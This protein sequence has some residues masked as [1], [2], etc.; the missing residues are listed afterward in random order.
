[1]KREK[2]CPSVINMKTY[3]LVIQF[4][5]IAVAYLLACPVS[6]SGAGAGHG[7]SATIQ[8]PLPETSYVAMEAQHAENSEGE[9]GLIE[10]LK[11]R[12]A[13]DP[14]NVVATSFV[15]R[16]GADGAGRAECGRLLHRHA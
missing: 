13:A 4:A 10:S 5:L 14:F 16:V 6:A 3:S 7:K 1:M 8:F 15:D 12:A 11:I 9:L 2:K